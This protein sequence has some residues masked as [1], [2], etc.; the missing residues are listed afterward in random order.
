MD[1]KISTGTTATGKAPYL[2]IRIGDN[3]FTSFAESVANALMAM[4]YLYDYPKD[5]EDLEMLKEPIARMWASMTIINDV[6]KKVE[7]RKWTGT[8]N[9]FES[10]FK[11][12]TE[13]LSL[14]IV[15]FSE[16][17][18][19][20]NYESICIPLFDTEGIRYEVR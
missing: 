14:R 13:R 1:K 9:N 8:P 2:V 19:W 6:M 20:D 4:F 11:Y 17:P 5:D 15:D 18:D 12:M 10:I 16:L 7:D 3:D